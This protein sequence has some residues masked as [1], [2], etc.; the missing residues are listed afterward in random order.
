MYRLMWNQVQVEPIQFLPVHEGFEGNWVHAK[1][2]R[3]IR[4]S[5]PNVGGHWDDPLVPTCT[6]LASDLWIED[7]TEEWTELARKEALAERLE[8]W[9]NA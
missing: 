6:V 1:C 3:R 7:W 9:W 4:M 8:Y 5:W 2:V